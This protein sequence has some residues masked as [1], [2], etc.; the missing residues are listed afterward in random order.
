MIMPLESLILAA[1]TAPEIASWGAGGL[2]SA[3]AVALWRRL[4]VV[5]DRERDNTIASTTAN[6][7]ASSALQAVATQMETLAHLVEK[8]SEVIADLIRKADKT[9]AA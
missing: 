2:A 3:A 8:Q 5:T 6:Y 1:S 7:A 9:G 4:W